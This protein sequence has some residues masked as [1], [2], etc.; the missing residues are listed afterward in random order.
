MRVSGFSRITIMKEP[1]V[2]LGP[3][4]GLQF[5]GLEALRFCNQGLSLCSGQEIMHMFLGFP[6]PL[7]LYYESLWRRR[8]HLA[9]L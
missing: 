4:H 1:P 6:N 2:A 7:T 3:V 9:F 8:L 5:F